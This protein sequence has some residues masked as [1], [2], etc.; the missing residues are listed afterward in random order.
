MRRIALAV[1]FVLGFVPQAW[2]DFLDGVAAYNRGDYVTAFHEMKPLAEKGI[3]EAQL[4]LGFMYTNGHGVPSD[5]TAAVKWYRLAAEQGLAQA[6]NA[7]G[8]MY[9]RGDGLPQDYAEATGWYRL[10][11]E[12]GH[13]GAQTL[14]LI[15]I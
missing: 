14:S 13:A 11:A 1:I 3:A 4:N 2:A 15:H 10:A 9:D 12:Q 7:L 8:V 6:Q 5:Y